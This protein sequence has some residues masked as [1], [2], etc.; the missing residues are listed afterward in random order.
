[1]TA[2]T[3]ISDAEY[4]AKLA[5]EKRDAQKS[6]NSAKQNSEAQAAAAADAQTSAASAVSA[7]ATDDSDYQAILT[8]A[9]SG[10]QLSQSELT[11][12]KERNPAAYARAIKADTARLDLAKQMEKSPSQASQALGGAL[13]ALSNRG[14]D[15]SKALAKALNDEYRSFAAKYDQS[16]IG[17]QFS[18]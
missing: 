14:D 6:A 11:I 17:T 12:L 9:N 3:G 15:D 13:S 4:L 2:V 18:E 10:Q 1:M 16:L 5:L 7:A 8:K